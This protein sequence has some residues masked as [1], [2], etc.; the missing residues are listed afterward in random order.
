MKLPQMP[1]KPLAFLVQRPDIHSVPPLA[2]LTFSH[3]DGWKPSW[4]AKCFKKSLNKSPHL[5]P[6]SQGLTP[7]VL[8]G[9]CIM[10]KNTLMA[11]CDRSV[12]QRFGFVPGMRCWVLVHHVCNISTGTCITH[13]LQHYEAR[14]STTG[15]LRACA[16]STILSRN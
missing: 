14:G 3:W 10:L 15:L 13:P 11:Q 12:Y 2:R 5:P 6:Y 7:S 8:N 1:D 4:L 16:R 9:Y